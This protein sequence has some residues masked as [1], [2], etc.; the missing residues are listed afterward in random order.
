M[1]ITNYYC[2]N[3]LYDIE[4]KILRGK[5]TRHGKGKKRNHSDSYRGY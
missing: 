2:S 5:T 4:S 3:L 1:G